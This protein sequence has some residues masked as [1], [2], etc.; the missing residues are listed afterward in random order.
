MFLIK[1]HSLIATMLLSLLLTPLQASSQTTSHE[2]EVLSDILE[3]LFKQSERLTKNT[4][5]YIRC[6]QQ[7]NPDFTSQ[8]QAENLDDVIEQL[9]SSTGSLKSCQFL[10]DEIIRKLPERLPDSSS[11]NSDIQA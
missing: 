3:K 9:E 7:H 1:Q 10:L 6:L 5:D 4:D 8:L 2:A 11:K